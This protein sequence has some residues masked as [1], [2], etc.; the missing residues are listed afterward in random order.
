LIAEIRRSVANERC[1]RARCTLLAG[2]A[3]GDVLDANSQ[4]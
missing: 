3:T 4:E 2:V 1:L